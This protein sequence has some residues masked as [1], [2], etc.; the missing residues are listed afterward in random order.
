MPKLT[1]PTLCANCCT[2]MHAGDNFRWQLKSGKQGG[3]RAHGTRDSYHPAHVE[4]CGLELRLMQ[5][6]AAE[7]NRDAERLA[8]IA[9]LTA[10]LE[11]GQLTVDAYLKQLFVKG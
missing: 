3:S 10:A 4:P 2:P 1:K 6:E 7:A 9:G 5:E 8:R 11:Q